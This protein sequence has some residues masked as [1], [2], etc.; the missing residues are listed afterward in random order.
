MNR[1]TNQKKGSIEAF[2][3]TDA[4]KN[5]IN[6]INFIEQVEL[7]VTVRAAVRGMIEIYLTSPM[8]TRSLILPVS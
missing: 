7:I 6:E 1:R 5:T 3:V 2:L 8:G 4:C